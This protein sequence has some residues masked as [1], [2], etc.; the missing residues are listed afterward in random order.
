G[1]LSVGGV[2][3]FASLCAAAF[4]ASTLLFLPNRWPL[5][6]SVPLLVFLCGY[7]FSK[8]FTALAHFWLGAALGLAPVAAWLALRGDVERPP[9]VLG[10]AVLFW[11]AGF[12]VIYACQDVEFD[13]RAGLHSMPARLG[14]TR[15][16][17]VAALCHLVTIV[18]LLLL[19]SVYP[20]LGWIYVSGIL[21]VAALLAYEHRLVRPDD[22]SRV[23]MA[24][25]NVNAVVSIGLFLI[26]LADL[27]VRG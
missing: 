9:L 8:R 12:D 2:T 1:M 21:A 24:F 7:S 17:R 26:G 4:V 25:F 18:A 3:T 13:V 14:V 16:L 23:N 10:V 20:R 27:F 11:V 19:P 22:L 5:W 6:L 15:A